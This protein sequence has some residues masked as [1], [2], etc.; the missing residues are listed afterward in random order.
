[1]TPFP[2][3]NRSPFPDFNVYT[4]GAHIVS[5]VPLVFHYMCTPNLYNVFNEA[6][7]QHLVFIKDH[8]IQNH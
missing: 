8:T 5:A 3:T 6:L 4:L 1:M 7:K 2:Y